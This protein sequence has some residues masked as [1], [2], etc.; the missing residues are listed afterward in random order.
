MSREVVLVLIDLY[1]F[2]SWRWVAAVERPVSD[3][4]VYEG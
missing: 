1:L 4:E 2:Q 3:Y